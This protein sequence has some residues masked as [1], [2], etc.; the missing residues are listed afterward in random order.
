[1]GVEEE[2]VNF[3]ERSDVEKFKDLIA[4]ASIFSH[5]Q[6]LPAVTPHPF[7]YLFGKGMGGGNIILAGKQG[8]LLQ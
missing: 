1:L 4:D 3:R 6:L 2:L 7:L 8:I 5:I